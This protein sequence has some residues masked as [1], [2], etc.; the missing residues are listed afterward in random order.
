V[1]ASPLAA[2]RRR[3]P[4]RPPRESCDLC[5]TP[6]ARRHRHLWEVPQRRLVCACDPCAV[7]FA[8]EARQRYRAVPEQVRYL[9]GFELPQELW[10]G[11]LVPVGMV[12]FIREE[13]P[14]DGSRVVA[15]YPSPAGA[16][17]S[18]LELEAWR[19]LEARNPIL[20]RMEPEVE[21]LLVNRVG[22]ARDHFLAPIDRCYELVGLIRAGWRGLSGGSELWRSVEQFFAEL[23]RQAV[24]SRCGDA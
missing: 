7:L 12:F 9:E 4:P 17:E 23:R 10:E 15:R 14:T 24:T 21:A 13:G 2:L 18:S 22:R 16:T 19:E 1:N 6:L 20:R 8:G 5:A 3:V 11:L